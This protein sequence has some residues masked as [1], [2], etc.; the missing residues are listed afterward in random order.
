M[1]EKHPIFKRSV[2]WPIF[3][4]STAVCVP[5]VLAKSLP[6][7]PQLVTSFVKPS[8]RLESSPQQSPDQLSVEREWQQRIVSQGLSWP[9]NSTTSTNAIASN[10]P[11]PKT[12]TPQ[13]IS[14]TSQTSTSGQ[15]KSTAQIPASTPSKSSTQ[16]SKSQSSTK[17]QSSIKDKDHNYT[18]KPSKTAQEVKI[19]VAIATDVKSLVVGTSTSSEVLNARGK[20]LGKLS[21]HEGQIVQ[22]DGSN[23][24]IGKWKTSSGV[25]VKPAQGGLV[26]VGDRWYRGHLMLVSQGNTLLAVNYVDLESY[27]ASV[28]GSEVSP[29][30]PMDAL[31]AQAIAARSYA[32]VHH[33]RPANSLYDLGNTQR[34]QVYRGI[35]SEWNTTHQAVQETHGVFLSYKGGVVESMYA[36]S[37][38]I[39]TKVF[40]GWGMSQNGALNLANQGYNYKQILGNYYPGTTLAWMN[41]KSADGE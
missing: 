20:G 27:I 33:M 23:I 35:S 15:Q 9:Q 4:V 18:P 22:P 2:L 13:S 40:D 28:V 8:P 21:A 41:T 25:W 7:R 5:V 24:R 31:K 3:L 1:P 29:S 39:V 6:P 34:W 30:W 37:D 12:D 19:R 17:S 36:A 26:F 16:P 10:S 38:E 32:L 11:V 14:P